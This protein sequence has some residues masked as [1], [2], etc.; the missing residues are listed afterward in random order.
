MKTTNLSENHKSA[1]RYNNVN[2]HMNEI[3]KD[4][5]ASV[6]NSKNEAD[7]LPEVKNNANN[8][9]QFIKVNSVL[10]KSGYTGR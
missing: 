10:P 9:N 4:N 7:L 1:N 6:Q 2:E 3:K 8:L 5:T